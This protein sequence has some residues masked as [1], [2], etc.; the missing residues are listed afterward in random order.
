MVNAINTL[1]SQWEQEIVPTLQA[2]TIG[3]MLMP[4]NTDLSGKG[5]GV[6]SIDTFNYV[7]RASAVINYDIQQDNSDRVDLTSGNLKIPLQ[8]D[9]V[10]IPRRDWDAYEL[11]GVPLES[12][13]ATDMAANVSIQQ[14]NLIIDGWKPNGSTYDIKGM[15]QVANNSV[16]GQDFD[17]F[18]NALKTT[19]EAITAL[20]A[21]KIYSAGYNL[22][23]SSLNYAELMGSYSTAGVSEYDL[24]L[25]MLNSDAG[26]QVTGRIL[27][28]TALSAGTGMVSPVAS[29]E[30]RRYFD[31][32]EP[33]E[34]S[35]SSWYTDGNIETGDIN[36]RLLGALIP[37]FKH[38]NGSGLDD[39][40]CKITGLDSS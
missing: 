13:L 7:A 2:N 5:I 30:N 1:K 17:T 31:L 19:A 6:L 8:Q 27:E 12:D 21:D 3:K 15:Y 16:S 28:G 38:L 36:F 14:N 40:I 22:T 35:L 33:Q 24:V 20:K 4:M 10:T 23:L 26:G 11:K 34:P 39:C 29:Q 18:G 37:R 9:D 25:R 32:I